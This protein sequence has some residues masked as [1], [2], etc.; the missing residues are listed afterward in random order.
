VHGP[1]TTCKRCSEY[2]LECKYEL[3]LG[4][5]PASPSSTASIPSSSPPP[6]LQSSPQYNRQ[7]PPV[8]SN[9]GASWSHRGGIGTNRTTSRDFLAPFDASFVSPSHSG[10]VQPSVARTATSP[11]TNAYGVLH[12][13]NI[14]PNVG[15]SSFYPP[16]GFADPFTI[17][18]RGASPRVG[19]PFVAPHFNPLQGGN[20]S[21]G[22][23]SYRHSGQ[24]PM[25]F[26]Q[27]TPTT[28]YVNL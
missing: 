26:T 21:V 20:N 11:S 27:P 8:R 16:Q 15:T 17:T 22:G 6:S 23:L 4:Q 2:G 19:S 1:N 13:G 28:T 25:D 3:P 9:P 7:N 18:D 24:G 14:Y 5:R 12:Q 10:N